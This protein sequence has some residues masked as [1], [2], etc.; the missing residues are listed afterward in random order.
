MVVSA[1]VIDVSGVLLSRTPGQS[2]SCRSYPQE[3]RIWAV[4]NL[5]GS[6]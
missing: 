2:G 3:T 5:V 6:W 4:R 1:T